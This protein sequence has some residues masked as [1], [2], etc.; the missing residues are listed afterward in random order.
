[1]GKPVQTTRGYGLA[2]TAFAALCLRSRVSLARVGRGY[3]RR[4]VVLAGVSFISFL[5][6]DNAPVPRS[7]QAKKRGV[8]HTRCIFLTKP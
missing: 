3:R 5:P 6:P 1:V 7:R 4:G 8:S 2:I